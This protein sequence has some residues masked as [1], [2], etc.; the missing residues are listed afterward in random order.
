MKIRSRI[1]LP[2]LILS[3]LF[4]LAAWLLFSFTSQWYVS[5]LASRSL[6]ELMGAT[7]TMAAQVYGQHEEG[8]PMSRDEEQDFSR[9]LMSQIK[10]LIR[11]DRPQAQLI[12]LNSKCRLTYP[13]GKNQQPETEDIYLAGL[14]LLNRGGHSLDGTIAVRITAGGTDYLLSIFQTEGDWNVRNKYLMGYVPVP[15]TGSLLSYTGSLLLVITIGLVLVSA[16]FAWFSARAIARPME[17]LC[18]RA[19]VIGRGDFE[20]I[21][22]HYPIREAEELKDSFNQMAR[23]LGQADARQKTF[24]QNASHEL[25]TPLMSICGYAQGIQYGVFPDHAHAAQII[26]AESMRLKEL[27]DDILCLS[28]IDSQDMALRPCAICLGDF[29]QEQLESLGGME[30]TE[31]VEFCLEEAEEP[32]YVTADS[33]LLQKAFLNAASNCA[34][35]ARNKVTVRL[36]LDSGMAVIRVEDDGPGF[37]P[38]DLPHLFELFY[39]GSGGNF[40][41]GLALARSSMEYMGGT[42]LA[43]NKKGAETGA[44]FT[45]SLPAN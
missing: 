16:V 45:L 43:E 23:Q 40:G 32:V 1:F 38:Q 24:F 3:M 26:V 25:R 7:R 33:S 34:R 10:S 19:A 35:Y 27:V 13:N 6:E 2:V 5:R 44:V 18:R 39:K 21:P 12:S 17:N 30:I 29:I 20:P 41:I 14:D 15:D 9:E 36:S 31:Q 8:R 28:K 37:S 4:P 11:R 42:I 22:V